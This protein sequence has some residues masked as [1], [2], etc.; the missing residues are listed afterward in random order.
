MFIS[1]MK[2][3]EYPPIPNKRYFRIGEASELCGVK[4]TVLRYWEKEF[5]QIRPKKLNGHRHYRLADIQIIRKIRDLLYTQ[6]FTITGAKQYLEAMEAREENQETD[7]SSSK[8]KYEPHS[9]EASNIATT[10]IEL[11]IQELEKLKEFL[12]NN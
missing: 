3:F 6:G 10:E 7:F 8:I 12:H 1:L 5:S 11:A 4:D 9:L 2:K